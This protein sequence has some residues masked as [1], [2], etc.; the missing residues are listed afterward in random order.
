MDGILPSY[1]IL[2]LIKALT[3]NQYDRLVEAKEI[4]RLAATSENQH[5]EQCNL[6]TVWIQLDMG[7]T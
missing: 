5:F 1:T 6:L 2:S 3:D 4:I 7:F